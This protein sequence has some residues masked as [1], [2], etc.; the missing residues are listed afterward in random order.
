[1]SDLSEREEVTRM[2]AESRVDV[3]AE[4]LRLIGEEPGR[5]TR[6]MLRNALA[7][8]CQMA[9]NDIF[10]VVARMIDQGEL[11]LRDVPGKHGRKKRFYLAE[12]RARVRTE[13]LAGSPGHESSP[14]PL[15]L[16]PTR[17]TRR[18]RVRTW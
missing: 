13:L 11:V 6:R 16:P 8:R 5:Y 9:K 3:R 17:P 1:V 10:P 2:Y 14:D 12:S 4:A 18:A 7:L 15:D